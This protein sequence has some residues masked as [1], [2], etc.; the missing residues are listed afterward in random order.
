MTK[1]KDDNETKLNQK[2]EDNMLARVPKPKIKSM[3]IDQIKRFKR[4]K[5]SKKKTIEEIEKELGFDKIEPVQLTPSDAKAM[6]EDGDYFDEWYEEELR[7]F[8]EK[9]KD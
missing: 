3:D 1:N 2:E 9:I 5:S 8:Y 4:I 6:E 7:E